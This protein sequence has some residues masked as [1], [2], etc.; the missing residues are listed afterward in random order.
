MEIHVNDDSKIVEVWLT[1]E[2]KR[3]QALRERL[4]Q[5][6]RECRAKKYMVAVFQSGEHD[7]PECT[8]DLLRYNRRRIAHMELQ[9]EKKIKE[10]QVR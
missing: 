3:S 7:L 5:L 8:S 4:K 1:N 9:R 10:E 6:Y 2:E